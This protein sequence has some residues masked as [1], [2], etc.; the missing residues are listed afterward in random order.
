[1]CYFICVLYWSTLLGGPIL[2]WGTYIDWGKKIR[3][4]E[5]MKKETGVRSP[6]VMS[7]YVVMF[8]PNHTTSFLIGIFL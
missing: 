4:Y 8:L 7:E 3:T 2:W 6:F 1:M 5:Q